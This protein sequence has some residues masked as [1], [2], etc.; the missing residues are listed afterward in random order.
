MERFFALTGCFFAM[1]AVVMGAFGSHLLQSKLPASSLNTLEIAVRYQMYHA[2]AIFFVVYAL[3]RW[4]SLA[5]SM[6]G[7]LFVFGILFFSGSLYVLIATEQRWL[8]MI[9]P[10]G[11][12]LLICGWINLFLNL[13]KA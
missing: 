5:I 10:I 6:S 7:W 8:G 12:I 9:T 4:P 13:L 2:L 3:G 11:G 1:T